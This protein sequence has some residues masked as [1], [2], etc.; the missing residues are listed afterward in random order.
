MQIPVLSRLIRKRRLERLVDQLESHET[1]M[2]HICAQIAELTDPG[3][4]LAVSCQALI[5]ALDG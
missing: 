2:R 3:D 5:E 1:A 4:D